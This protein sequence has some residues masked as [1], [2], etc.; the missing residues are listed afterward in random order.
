MLSRNRRE[1][2]CLYL[3]I[4]STSVIPKELSMH[5]A[6]L[7]QDIHPQSRAMLGSGWPLT[8]AL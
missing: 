3:P 8:S 1:K 6:K 5:A 2:L 4:T 7:N